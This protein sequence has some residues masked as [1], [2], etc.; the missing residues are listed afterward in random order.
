MCALYIY[1]PSLVSVESCLAPRTS[2]TPPS[3][4]PVSRTAVEAKSVAIDI[5]THFALLAEAVGCEAVD[6]SANET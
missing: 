1:N 4:F 5:N 6:A 3:Y 2:R